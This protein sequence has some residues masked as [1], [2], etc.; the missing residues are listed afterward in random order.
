MELIAD[1]TI[2]YSDL[3]QRIQTW[4]PLNGHIPIPATTNISSVMLFGENKESHVVLPYSIVYPPS[5]FSVSHHSIVTV[6]KNNVIYH[7]ALYAIGDGKR[8][9]VTLRMATGNAEKALTIYDYDTIEEIGSSPQHEDTIYIIPSQSTSHP[10]P[11]GAFGSLQDARD[12]PAFTGPMTITYL[13]DFL[14]WQSSYTVLLDSALETIVMLRLSAEITNSGS[15]QF[16]SAKTSLLAGSV[17]QGPALA[18]TPS[19]RKARASSMMQESVAMA[20]M[21]TEFSTSVAVDEYLEFPIGPITVGSGET[22]PI[23]LFTLTAIS[24]KKIYFASLG[25]DKTITFGYRFMSPRTLPSGTMIVYSTASTGELLGP[26]LG[27]TTIN[28]SREH[29]SVDLM[30]GSTSSIKIESN[31]ESNLVD[32]VEKIGETEGPQGT[33][34]EGPQGV[35]RK[36]EHLTMKAKITNRNKTNIVLILRRYIYDS[37]IISSTYTTGWT[38]TRKGPLVEFRG[39]IASAP[40]VSPNSVD[41]EAELILE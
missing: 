8:R 5:Y 30:L 6:R 33:K 15:S 29:D 14:T 40:D 17:R 12:R 39:E 41:F 22:I 38:M 18:R 20:V 37:R 13:I 24:A 36:Q 31:V 3:G 23:E 16:T 28:E 4:N 19:V 26:F 35:K 11:L 1:N 27:S 9:S 25:D 34:T 7:G 2:L 10:S 21:P 32:I